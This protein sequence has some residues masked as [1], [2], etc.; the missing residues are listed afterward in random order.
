MEVECIPV[1]EDDARFIVYRPLAR[2]AFVGNLPMAELAAAAA[3][4]QTGTN[5]DGAVG[6][7]RSI[8]F[9][10]PDPEAPPPATGDFKPTTAV[11]LLTNQCQLRCTYCY[12]SAGELPRQ[13]LSIALGR[14]VIDYVLD[15]ARASGQP[16]FEVSFHGGGEPTL[17]WSTLTACTTYA[18]QQPIPAHITL[19]S[20]GIW[21]RKQC[22]WVV[23]NIDRLSLSID[24]DPETQDGQ[25]P[26]ASGRG[27]SA[28]AMRTVEELDRHAFRYGIRMTAT[29]PWTRLR[30]Q[31]RFLCE[32]TGC[33]SIQVEPAFNA[34]RGGHGEPTT[35]DGRAYADAFLEAYD[36]ADRAGRKLYYSGAR[37]GVVTSAFCT[38]P[39]DALVV[40]ALG[41]LVTCY[42]IAGVSHPLYPLSVMGRVDGST[43]VVD[44]D[45]RDHLH[46]L[47]EARRESCRDCYCHWSCAGDCYTRTFGPGPEGHLKHGVR[48]AINRQITR[49]LLLRAIAA[50]GGVWRGSHQHTAGGDG[51]AGAEVEMRP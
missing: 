24:G 20:N 35:A 33:Q 46:A 12:A 28:L 29:A 4:G 2:L 39:F 48:C 36:L 25:R 47:M 15:C 1:S 32:Q 31:V 17:A 21:S 16:K 18:R 34:A 19:T 40:N 3:R 22:S 14:A 10:D 30:E 5:R 42:E 50:G 26:F 13:Q 11:L 38:A 9:L 7:L 43:V 27:S 49:Q 51:T 44:T 8:G 41:D 37:L 23:D 6:F 45:A